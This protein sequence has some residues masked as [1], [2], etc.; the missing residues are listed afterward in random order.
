[1]AAPATAASDGN[2]FNIRVTWRY[3]N[4]VSSF[5][6]LLRPS[7]TVDE[8]RQ[9]LGAQSPVSNSTAGELSLLSR[10]PSK[11]IKVEGNLTVHELGVRANQAYDVRFQ[12]AARERKKRKAAII[13]ETKFPAAIAAQDRLANEKRKTPK[14][15]VVSKKETKIMGDGNRLSD[16]TKVKGKYPTV[17]N[18]KAQASKM[19]GGGQRL[20]DGKHMT[21]PSTEMKRKKIESAIET[22]DN[23]AMAMTMINSVGA[24]GDLATHLRNYMALKL[25]EAQ[26]GTRAEKRLNA[27]N[28][29]NYNFKSIQGGCAAADGQKMYT[30]EYGMVGK[31]RRGGSGKE[32]KIFLV[33][34][35]KLKIALL[36]LHVQSSLTPMHLAQVPALFWSLVKNFHDTNQNTEPVD[37]EEML[38]ATFHKLDWSHLDRGGRKREMSVIGKEAMDNL[39]K[40]KVPMPAAQENKVDCCGWEFCTPNAVQQSELKECIVQGALV[41]VANSSG[42]NCKEKAAE[43]LAIILSVQVRNWRELANLLSDSLLWLLHGDLKECIMLGASVEEGEEKQEAEAL[44]M[45]LLS[46]VPNWRELANTSYDTL[47][48]TLHESCDS[49]CI[50]ERWIVYAQFKSLHEIMMEILDENSV[51]YNALVVAKACSPMG[52]IKWNCPHR[53]SVLL[54]LISIPEETSDRWSMLDIEKWISRANTVRCTLKWIELYL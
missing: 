27:L 36:A 19:G 42:T 24:C 40:G 12:Q 2:E 20:S 34:F 13:A 50:V 25:D 33:N 41:G 15:K 30:V 7:S 4:M 32:D 39:A 23:G 22:R 37:V 17:A 48:P 31:S 1:M 44:S 8:L 18:K 11:E 3:P 51:A 35:H 47:L 54:S 52:L 6:V 14:R 38:R 29:V 5:C 43:A 53:R 21:G 10:C 46:A 49:E 45:N 9:L 26:E 28:E 16:G